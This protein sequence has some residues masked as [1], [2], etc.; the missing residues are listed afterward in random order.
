M[1]AAK[2]IL[3]SIVVEGD[4]L[5]KIVSSIRE[6]VAINECEVFKIR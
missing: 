2:E 4:F 5:K 3:D 6:R 1:E